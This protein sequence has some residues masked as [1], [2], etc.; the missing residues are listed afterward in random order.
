MDRYERFGMADRA[1]AIGFW[2]NAVLMTMKLSAGHFGHSDAVF[3][4]GMESAADFVAILASMIA[5]K[6]GRRPLD[7]DHP[8]GHG[9]AESI[10]AI[11]VSLIIFATGGG[12]L[13]NAVTTIMDKDYG[14]PQL[15]AVLAALATIVI[16]EALFRYTRKVSKKLQSPAVEA[17]ARDHRKDALTSLVTL[18]GVGG[19][20]FGMGVMD[21]LAA[22]LTSLF[23]GRIGWETFRN[24]AND[25][26]DVQP[27]KE[28]ITAVTAIAE[29]VHGVEHVHEIRS[30]RSGQYLI[31][32]L[33]LDMDPEMTVKQSHGIT[34]DVK[35]LIFERFPNVGDVMIHIN[36]H[37][38][39]HEDLVR[40]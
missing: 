18:V 6:I 30:R 27:P 5:L 4:D 1:I 10:A 11:L 37:D 25:L 28:L 12:I 9:K 15:I 17:I 36:P 7:D 34:A 14:T 32:D 22:G 16:K 13:F 35:R 38:E 33:K 29:G 21:H 40:L 19:A 39:E 8:Y 24:A 20:Y 31:V 3:A 23:I 2:I 26:M